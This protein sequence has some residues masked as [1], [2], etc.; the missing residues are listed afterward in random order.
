MKKYTHLTPDQQREICR[1]YASGMEA[2]EI[3]PLFDKSA[4]A[5]HN[6]LKKHGI[7]RR[8]H[9]DWTGTR[10]GQLT[11]LGRSPGN[12]KGR[13]TWRCQCDCG[14]YTDARMHQLNKGITTHCNAAHHIRSQFPEDNLT[15]FRNNKLL[16]TSFAGYSDCRSAKRLHRRPLW[17][18][19]CDC[20]NTTTIRGNRNDIPQSCGCFGLESAIQRQRD[21]ALSLVGSTVNG[22][23]IRHVFWEKEGIGHPRAQCQATCP[24][25][26]VT[27]K[28]VLKNLQR[29]NSSC[30]CLALHGSDSIALWLSGEFRN[31]EEDALF[32]LCSMVNHPEHFKPGIAQSMRHRRYAGQGEYGEQLLSI[33]L[34]RI[35]AWL[36]EQAVLHETRLMTNWPRRLERSQW[37]GRTELRRMAPDALIR[38]ATELHEQL[39]ELGRDEFALRYVPMTAEQA[40]Q[41]STHLPV[42]A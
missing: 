28:F 21:K 33:H 40:E 32:Y 12:Q 34:P 15:G 8:L 27:K 31:P 38:I 23:L 4:S 6:C 36:L 30:G 19:V 41:I 35:E 24:Y 22:F 5:I 10:F 13:A 25:C 17:N 29:Q 3:A 7:T 16:I 42:A 18:A 2:R 26:K 37:T 20:G 11:V 9:K 1:L 14:N 39:L